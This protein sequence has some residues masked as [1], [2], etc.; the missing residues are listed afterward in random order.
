MTAIIITIV[1]AAIATGLLA[2]EAIRY[3][4]EDDVT[5]GDV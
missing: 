2:W 5:D 3:L 1:C 4:R